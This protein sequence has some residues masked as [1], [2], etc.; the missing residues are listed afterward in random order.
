MWAFNQ[1]FREPAIETFVPDHI[2][3]LGDDALLSFPRHEN[4]PSAASAGPGAC[5]RVGGGGK[6]ERKQLYFYARTLDTLTSPAGRNWMWPLL[7]TDQNPASGWRGYDYIINSV[8]VGGQDRC[9][10]ERNAGGW[11]WEKVVELKLEVKA[12]ELHLALGL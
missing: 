11:H 3:R 4:K 10:L 6:C 7:V 1:S 2:S 8:G 9:W 5:H 12:N